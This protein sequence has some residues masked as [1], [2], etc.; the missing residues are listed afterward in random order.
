MNKLTQSVNEL[1]IRKRFDSMEDTRTTPLQVEGN[2]SPLE[3]SRQINARSTLAL[4]EKTPVLSF[5]DPVMIQVP[6][7]PPLVITDLD[8]IN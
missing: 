6:A 4:H 1:Q 3:M 2:R 8:R 7:K 5:P